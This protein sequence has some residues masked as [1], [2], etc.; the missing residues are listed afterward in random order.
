MWIHIY[1]YIYICIYIHIYSNHGPHENQ[2]HLQKCVKH[3]R[4]K[5]ENAIGSSIKSCTCV[6]G[7]NE[8]ESKRESARER[9]R[10]RR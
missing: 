9:E 3:T 8:R 7:P 6:H 5:F 2:M 1:M 10:E 4:H